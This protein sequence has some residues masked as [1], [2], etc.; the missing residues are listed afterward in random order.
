MTAPVF[1]YT[2]PSSSSSRI[3]SCMKLICGGVY[4]RADIRTDSALSRSLTTRGFTFAGGSAPSLSLK[5]S[6]HYVTNGR[7]LYTIPRHFCLLSSRNQTF[8]SVCQFFWVSSPYLY[9]MVIYWV[10]IRNVAIEKRL[11]IE[12]RVWA[13]TRHGPNIHFCSAVFRT[14]LHQARSASSAP[15]ASCFFSFLPVQAHP[16]SLQLTLEYRRA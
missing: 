3:F 4:L 6:L 7:K 8:D 16:S 11:I 2:N 5:I 13:V 9:I 14:G 10:I 1:L 12:V 15:D